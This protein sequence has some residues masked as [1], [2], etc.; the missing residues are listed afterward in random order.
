LLAAAD[1]FNAQCLSPIYET[2]PRQVD[3][4]PPYLNAVA[5]CLTSLNA[6][7]FLV[8]IHDLEQKMGRKRVPGPP[9]PRTLDIDV[10]TFGNEPRNIPPL[11]P[12]PRLHLRAFVLKPWSDI[13]PEFVVPGHNTSVRQLY[14]ALDE[15][16][17]KSVRRLTFTHPWS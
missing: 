9:Q 17:K 15:K 11:V 7:E 8:A 6:E 14:E 16:E 2:E 1:A 13:A 12:H 4:H 3:H 5:F 10:L